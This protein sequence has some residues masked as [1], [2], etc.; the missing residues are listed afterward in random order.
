MGRAKV[1]GSV[2]LAHKLSRNGSM[3]YAH[4]CRNLM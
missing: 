3:T 1:F 2:H 4:I